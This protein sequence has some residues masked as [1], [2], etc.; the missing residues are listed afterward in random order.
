MPPSGYAQ[1]A[2]LCTNHKQSLFT[3]FPTIYTQIWYIVI[4][5]YCASY[6][7]LTFYHKQIISMN[8]VNDFN[9]LDLSY[10]DHHDLQYF[11]HTL[12]KIWAKMQKYLQR[13]TVLILFLGVTMITSPFFVSNYKCHNL[14]Q[15]WSD[16]RTLLISWP[17]DWYKTF[18]QMSNVGELKQKHNI[19]SFTRAHSPVMSQIQVGST[20]IWPQNTC[21]F[22]S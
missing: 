16:S 2:K 11:R 20:K 13:K 8:K 4:I 1:L 7:L 14:K 9:H 6:S 15:P 12:I 22:G 17:S 21:N 5:L 18:C 10:C 3:C 19:M